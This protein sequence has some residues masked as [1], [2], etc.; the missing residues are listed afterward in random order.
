MT[1]L[2]TRLL[3]AG[4]LTGAACVRAVA[5]GLAPAE[6]DK[7][8]G[9]PADIAPS[10]YLYRADRPAEENPPEAWV[11]LMQHANLPFDQPVDTNAPAVKQALC[12]LL[13]E[14]VRPVRRLVL[15]WPRKAKNK[16]APDQLVVSCFNGQDDTAHTWWNPR[17][18]K[19]AAAPEVSADGRTYSYAIP[20]DT[21][22]V[23]VAVRGP[24]EASAFA[25]PALQAFVADQ[26]KQMDV[27]I[28]WGYR[29]RPA[30]HSPM[31]GTLRSMMVGW[32]SSRRWGEIRGRG[33]PGRGRGGRRVGGWGNPKAEIRRPKEGR[34]PKAEMGRRQAA[35]PPAPLRG[36]RRRESCKE[37]VRGGACGFGCFTSAIHGGV[38]CGPIMPRLRM[39]REPSLPCGPSRAASLSWPQTS[40]TDRSWLPNTASSSA[41]PGS[42]SRR[43]AP[44]PRRRR[45]ATQGTAGY[46][47]GCDPGRAARAGLVHGRDSL[48]RRQ[49]GERAGRRGRPANP[50][51][52]CRHAPVAGPRCGR[53]LAQP[54]PGSGEHQGQRGD[55]RRAWRQRHR[56]GDC[57]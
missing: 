52:V 29:V 12:G 30:R 24:K 9:Q 54:A 7:L 16:P 38:G 11:L 4:L 40:N 20:V 32:R 33:S 25:V 27:E 47:G 31:M 57:A 22:G 26:W 28:E 14:E 49:P 15:S 36:Q 3:A 6:V 41:P 1:C 17:T 2:W 21:W 48:V 8:A 56:M 13:W 10:A 19:E 18:V 45:A 39:W 5:A 55:G 44:P 43:P 35:R 51:T 50:R 46:E 37:E 34:I 23:V 53:W 42:S